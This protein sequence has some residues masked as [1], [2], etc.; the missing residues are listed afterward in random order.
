MMLSPSY[1]DAKSIVLCISSDVYIAPI[2]FASYGSKR[3]K[4]GAAFDE[5]LF[6]T[7]K[8]RGWAQNVPNPLFVAANS[9][10]L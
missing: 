10:S 2:L 4:I 9:G 8:L 6:V 1:R 3:S 7:T 5:S